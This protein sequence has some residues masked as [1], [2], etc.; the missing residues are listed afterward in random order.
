[1]RVRRVDETGYFTSSLRALAIS[2]DSDGDTNFFGI[3][4]DGNIREASNNAQVEQ[5]FPVPGAVY[6]E[7]VGGK[8]THVQIES[9]IAT[10]FAIEETYVGHNHNGDLIFGHGTIFRAAALAVEPLQT[11]LTDPKIVQVSG[12]F[13]RIDG[14]GELRQVL[15]TVTGKR[16]N[17]G[18]CAPGQA[19]IA[20]L[21]ATRLLISDCETGGSLIDMTDATRTDTI[22]DMSF[23]PNEFVEQSD[24]VIVGNSGLK[25]YSPEGV[26]TEI[27]AGDLRLAPGPNALFANDT[28]IV[29]RRINEIAVIKRGEAVVNLDDTPAPLIV[30]DANIIRVSLTGNEVYYLAEDRDGVPLFGI[31]NLATQKKNERV[32]DKS[33]SELKTVHP[34]AIQPKAA[35]WIGV[36]QFQLID[37]CGSRCGSRRIQDV[38]LGD[39]NSD[40]LMDMVA[41]NRVVLNVGPQQRF[42]SPTQIKNFDGKQQSVSLADM[43]GD[44]HLDLV[45]LIDQKQ[46]VVLLGDGTGS[47]GPPRPQL[48]DTTQARAFALADVNNDQHLDVI[49]VGEKGVHVLLGLGNGRLVDNA[50]QSFA[51]DELADLAVGDFNDDNTVDV[52]A[53]NAAENTV[54]ILFGDRTGRFEEQGLTRLSLG[55]SGVGIPNIAEKVMVADINHDNQPDIVAVGSN[56]YG[57]TISIRLGGSLLRLT[58][59]PL[60]T[61]Y[62]YAE[63]SLGDVDEDGNTDILVTNAADSLFV[64]RGDGDGNFTLHVIHSLGLY[65]TTSSLKLEDINSDGHLD[66]VAAYQGNIAIVLGNGTPSL[67]L[68]N[69]WIHKETDQ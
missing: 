5:F 63:M 64:M 27:A 66:L 19:T 41:D 59:I 22:A 47:F 55:E 37:D 18:A 60:R 6:I 67:T 43:N 9:E 16:I 45:S 56:G 69:G 58:T 53:I 57:T 35:E 61:T 62:G 46:V 36:K 39:I 40:G 21:S 4:A 15:D 13:A 1:M 51:E 3:D 44:T 34:L 68:E 50:I 52:A 65:N 24:G 10:S 49:L 17:V 38:A 25:H 48:L 23:G 26:V 2:A 31:Y 33:F 20:A 42:A 11:T 28:H 29:V 54:T 8:Q 14:E 12:N 7:L 32:N 30:E